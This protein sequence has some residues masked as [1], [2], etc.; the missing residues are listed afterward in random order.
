MRTRLVPMLA[1][2]PAFVLAV[3]ASPAFATFHLMQIHQVVGGVNGNPSAQAI[4]LR[5]RA[6]GQNQV[7][8]ARLI[9]W[10]ATGANPVLVLDIADSVQT[11]V[12]GATVLIASSGFQ[13][14]CGVT[15][16][17]VMT[18]P[19]P[20]SYLPAG[21]LTFENDAGTLI[22]WRLSWG[23]AAYTGPTNGSTVNDADGEFGP[24]WSGSL[25]SAGVEALTFQGAATDLST[26]NQTDYALSAPS[27]WTSND[28]T[29]CTLTATSAPEVPIAAVP[30]PAT[31]LSV[32]P[33]PFRP[34][35]T[36][37]FELASP[38]RTEIVVYDVRGHRVATLAD[39]FRTPGRY[40]TTWN[41]RDDR[42]HVA[43]AGT[44][45]LRL[46]AGGEVQ[47]WKVVLT[48]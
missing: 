31:I 8:N 45:F 44:Y 10:D 18:N 4:E 3:A 26:S 15:P 23:G 20:A 42:G 32:H 13:L 21:S 24:P 25:P 22:V 9:A 17:F 30:G 29:S 12:A 37:E 33:N 11:A 48:R 36:V 16:D 41:G 1:L 2:A 39:S 14:E 19:I 47:A 35:T 34:E 7:Q 40:T 6:A 38:S 5:M 28:G 43:A 46:S 27:V